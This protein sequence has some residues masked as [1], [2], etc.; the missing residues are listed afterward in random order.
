MIGTL[1]AVVF[2]APEARRLAAFYIA[3]CGWKELYTEDDWI[4]MQTGD[5]WR[6]AVQRS[7]DHVPPRWPDP[8]YPQQAHLDLARDDHEE[9]APPLT[10][11][12]QDLALADIELVR[13]PGDALQLL[14]GAVLEQRRGLDQRDLRVRPESHGGTL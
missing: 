9:L 12:D 8:A 13:D 11:P 3:L 7:P 5:G 10:L 2:D 6:I 14:L 4:A 1:R